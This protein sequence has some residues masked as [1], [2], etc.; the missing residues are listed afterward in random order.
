V[1]GVAGG[2]A[3]Y[4]R[5][6]PMWFR[7]AFGLGGLYTGALLWGA[8]TDPYD[9]FSVTGF[10]FGLVVALLAFAAT[11]T[12][13]LLWWLVPREDLAESAAERLSHRY[14]SA[15]RWPGIALLGVGTAILLDGLGVW[16][17]NVVIAAALIAGGVLLYRRDGA[18]V[19]GS[20]AP[21]R[22]LE[23]GTAPPAY[24]AERPVPIVLPP[25][26]RS[27][28]GWMTMGVALLVVGGAVAWVSTTGAAPRLVTIPSLAL[29]V[30]AAGLLVGTFV[31]RARWLALPALLLVP[32]VLVASLVRIPLEGRFG[33]LNLSPRSAA[34]VAGPYRVGFGRISID[35]TRLQEQQGEVTISTTTV[36]G[37]TW[38]YVPYDAHVVATTSTG[39]GSLQIMDE[40]FDDG[41]DADL[42]A[43]S[44]PRWGDGMTI[45]VAAEAG[46]GSI[47]IFRDYPTRR[48]LRELKQERHEARQA[49][50]EA[51]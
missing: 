47:N 4:Y 8:S 25:R 22:S 31:G 37:D 12:Y 2:L 44:E 11:V 18:A 19:V 29:L 21:A 49:E 45:V 50:R 3:D 48:E 26:E 38:I 23:S 28:L 33:D 7:A 5:T 34:E 6:R 39:Y 1:A 20:S 14:P 16:R 17:T 46:L 35:L 32:V 15:R 13:G 40:A 43:R 42:S 41:V 24:A 30:I 51:E 9:E 10:G 36:V 27:A